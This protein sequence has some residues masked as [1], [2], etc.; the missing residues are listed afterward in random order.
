M[1]VL[2]IG[3]LASAAGVGIDTVRFYERKGLLAEPARSRAGYRCYDGAAV[4]RLV[5][6]RRAKALGFTLGEIA[7][8]LGPTALDDPSAHEMA[9]AP[10]ATSAG[11][12]GGGATTPERIA[13]AATE[14]LVALDAEME[15]LQAVRQR[16][17]ALVGHCV[18]GDGPACVRLDPVPTGEGGSAQ[19]PGELL[20]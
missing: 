14:K 2:S 13:A 10:R 19:H 4:E 16:L 5:W 15:R 1:D 12:V 18:G 17:E 6:I 7:E 9:S 8:L 3:E 11:G 20:P